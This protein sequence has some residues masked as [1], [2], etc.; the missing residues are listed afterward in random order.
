MI[1]VIMG[2]TASGKSRLALETAR[3]I[4]GEDAWELARKIV[5]DISEGGIPEIDMRSMFGKKWTVSDVLKNYTPQEA[6]AKLEAY[7]KEQNEIKVGDVV[8]I[9]PNEREWRGVVI[10][11]YAGNKTFFVLEQDG[12]MQTWYDEQLKKIGKHIDIQSILQQIGG[13]ANVLG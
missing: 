7:E 1:L 9:E 5:L 11:K 13:E 2:P 6:L 8:E 10:A 12:E 4:N 3:Q